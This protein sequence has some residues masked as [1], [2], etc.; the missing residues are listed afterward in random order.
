MVTFSIVRCIK[1]YKDKAATGELYK[2]YPTKNHRD[3]FLTQEGTSVLVVNEF[4]ISYRR[5]FYNY[6]EVV[7]EVHLKNFVECKE[8]A[9]KSI[10]EIMTYT[11]DR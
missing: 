6:F 7:K 1:S 5:P 4:K 2:A 3:R 11:K 9:A 8:F 10:E